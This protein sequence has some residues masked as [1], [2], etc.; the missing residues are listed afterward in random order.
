MLERFPVR[1]WSEGGSYLSVSVI[2]IDAIPQFVGDLVDGEQLIFIEVV[3]LLA[4]FREDLT[5]IREHVILV[6]LAVTV[7]CHM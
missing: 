3:E 2:V 6:R 1:C 7:S 5:F 4:T